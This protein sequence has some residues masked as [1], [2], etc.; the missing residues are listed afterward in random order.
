MWRH[1]LV[2]GPGLLSVLGVT[3]I[4]IP[5]WDCKKEAADIRPCLRTTRVTFFPQTGRSLCST[6]T[7]ATAT[8]AS[9]A[10]KYEAKS[11]FSVWTFPKRE[12]RGE[13]DKISMSSFFLTGS[14]ATRMTVTACFTVLSH[15][16]AEW[17]CQVYI[18]YP[19][20]QKFLADL[21]SYMHFYLVLETK[22]KICCKCT[23]FSLFASWR[24]S[25]LYPCV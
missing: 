4:Q 17:K 3:G 1:L 13:A 10:P 18:V 6:A 22:T 15:Q 19:V 21:C 12:A 20:S 7:G 11:L 16:L 23:I 2:G 9:G 24:A 8:T 25:M 5:Y 14:L